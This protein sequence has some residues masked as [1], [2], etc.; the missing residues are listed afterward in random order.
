MMNPTGGG[1]ESAATRALSVRDVTESA[2]L[3][4]ARLI[5]GEAGLG[6]E[7]E[8]LVVWDL[9]LER[10]FVS[11]PGDLIV[12]VD[13]ITGRRRGAAVE[14]LIRRAR[15][16]GAA[17]LVAMVQVD[18]L[19]VSTQR[20]ADRVGLPLLAVPDNPSPMALVTALHR[21]VHA[22]DLA[23]A[24]A[25]LRLA[26]VTARPG[27]D[28]AGVVAAL[29]EIVG[30][31]AAVCLPRGVFAGDLGVVTMAA[32]RPCRVRQHLDVGAYTA[33][34]QPVVLTAADEPGAWLVL[35]REAAS[36]HWRRLAE[37]ALGLASGAATA[38]LARAQLLDERSYRERARTLGEILHAHDTAGPDLVTSARRLGMTLAGWHVGMHVM[39]PGGED[40]PAVLARLE[41][42]L[43]ALPA[44]PVAEH[45]DGW[46]TWY[47]SRDLPSPG[48]I[49]R[50][51]AQVHAALLPLTKHGVR[52]C[53]GVGSAQRDIPGISRTLTQA[54][55][56]AL[57]AS[58]AEGPVTV[59]IGQDLGASRMLLGWYG[60]ESFRDLA[61]DIVAPLTALGDDDL[62][63]TVAAYLDRACSASHTARALGVHRNTVNQRITRAEAVLGASFTDADTRL[64]LQLALRARMR[65]Q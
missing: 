42:A 4:Q 34:V 25:L 31:T 36:S 13:S 22:P 51:A 55:Q 54:R 33:V 16:G 44:G 23:A 43:Q 19:G 3:T 60:S 15:S 61:D 7:V 28:A 63:R 26:D 35:G 38:A 17:G 27:L 57:V 1:R 21:T 37:R 45:G 47:S 12:V 6:R 29:G 39:A 8:R 58:T 53:V 32:I 41:T 5:G 2:V 50:L 14:A 9:A 64:A 49:R 65:R 20:L 52:Y 18:D 10:D 62:V 24:E 11:R 40:D 59:R 48:D 56:A 46:A 30:G